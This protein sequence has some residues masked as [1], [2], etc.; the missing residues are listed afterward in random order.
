MQNKVYKDGGMGPI[1]YDCFG[2]A[3]EVY[4][5][6]GITLP[7]DYAVPTDKYERDATIRTEMG[8]ERYE[9]IFIPEAPALVAFAIRPPFVTHVG[10]LIGP[11]E[12]IHMIENAGVC[13]NKLSHP[14]WKKR[15]AGIYR[16]KGETT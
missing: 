6:F 13:V 9:E 11:C 2:F 12:F 15:V 10:V 7:M 16:Y 8:G 14:M 3:A 5:Q 4:R 1:E